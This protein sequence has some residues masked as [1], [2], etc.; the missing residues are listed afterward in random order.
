MQKGSPGELWA[1]LT[2]LYPSG[3]LREVGTEF[4][5]DA[6]A[7]APT[8]GPHVRARVLNPAGTPIDTFVT[9]LGDG[10]YRV[11]YTPFEEGEGPPQ[12]PQGPPQPPWEPQHPQ[13]PPQ[14]PWEPQHDL[15][16]PRAPPGTLLPHWTPK[17]SRDPGSW[18]GILCSSWRILRARPSHTTSKWGFPSIPPGS[19][20]PGTHKLPETPPNPN[21]GLPATPR[22]S[23]RDPQSPQDLPNPTQRPPKSPENPH[24][25]DPLCP[26]PGQCVM[27]SLSQGFTWWR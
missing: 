14:P 4:T 13:G 5:V 11:E 21:Q 8:G 6:R 19:P 22:T 24:P 18:P 7:L 9:D 20:E 12:H 15:Q 27:V 16:G 2:P 17:P 26:L 25:R 1:P 10:T 23:S 3:V